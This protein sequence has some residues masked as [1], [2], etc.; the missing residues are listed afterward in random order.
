MFLIV[1]ILPPR[2]TAGDLFQIFGAYQAGI[3][4]PTNDLAWSST[5]LS[6][7]PLKRGWNI[8][9]DGVYPFNSEVGIGFSL[10]YSLF[11]IKASGYNGKYKI[12]HI[13]PSLFIGKF[14]PNKK[15]IAAGFINGGYSV[16]FTPQHTDT[17]N[18][19]VYILSSRSDLGFGIGGGFFCGYRL[20]ESFGV[21]GTFTYDKLILG[22]NGNSGGS[23]LSFKIGLLVTVM[24]NL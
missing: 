6:N 14:D 1:F 2:I 3:A 19:G 5:L 18:S 24:E 9:F 13:K 7:I 17:T 16:Q 11:P 23:Y 8:G 10:L 15:F 4:N 20:S 21:S 22:S 12:L